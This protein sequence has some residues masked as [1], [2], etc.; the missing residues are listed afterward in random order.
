M[1]KIIKFPAPK[2]NTFDGQTVV[3]CF[4]DYE[5]SQNC[6]NTDGYMQLCIKCGKCGRKFVNGILQKE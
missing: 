6:C 4:A 1:G 2:P 3:K 5:P